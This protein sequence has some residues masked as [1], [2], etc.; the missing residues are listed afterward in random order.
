MSDRIEFEV[1]TPERRVVA[2]KV[3]EVVLPSAEGYMGVRPGHAP[4]LAMLDA[5]EVSYRL[6]NEQHYLAVSGGFAEVLRDSVS[7]MAS[8]SE[9]AEEIDLERAERSKAR[10]ETELK[11]NA[12]GVAFARAEVRLKKAISRIQVKGRAKR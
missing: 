10:A 11:A 6:G 3:D 2:E 7:I 4:L 1:V 5:G 8:T 12:S 9:R